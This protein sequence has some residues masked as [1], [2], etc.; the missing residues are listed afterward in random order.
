[1]K[2]GIVGAN[3]SLKVHGVAWQMFPGVEVAAVCTSRQETAERA[4]KEYGVPRAYWNVAEMAADP[5]LDIIDVGSRPSYRPPMV[6]DALRGGKHVYNALPFAT[7]LAEAQAQADL[8]RS[9]GK[10]GVVDA[11]FRYVPAAMQMKRMIDEGFI[12]RPLGFT[13]RLVLPLVH[14]GAL[15]YPY[16]AYPPADVQ[17]YKWL[18]EKA[19]GASAWRN[20]GT[21]MTLLL[22]HM[23]GR[24][25]SVTGMVE[26]GM[27]DWSLPDGSALKAETDDLGCAVMQMENGAIGT[28]Q[29]GWCMPDADFIMLDVWG[30]KGRLRYTDR[31]FGDGISAELYAAGAKLKVQGEDSGSL[32]AID[33]EF[34]RVP[35]MTWDRASAPPYMTSMG[36]MFHNMLEAI[37]GRK[38]A[39]PSFDDALHAHS[40]VEALLQSA[41]EGRHIKV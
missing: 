15:H 13:G 22:N 26:T 24:V 2:V 1:M 25:A 21:H 38:P 39:S 18:A 10:I 7:N 14:D 30:D 27:K 19:S 41:A 37:A 6:M 17:P 11:Q 5:D 20:Y 3:W 8:A 4:A 23:I 16:A 35:G 36:W 31:S 34:F 32:V 28:L 12:G 33:D 40:V 9:M 29:V